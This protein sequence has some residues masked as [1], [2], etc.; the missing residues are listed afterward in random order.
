MCRSGILGPSARALLSLAPVC[1]RVPTYRFDKSGLSSAPPTASYW[2]EVT[3][4]S[5]SAQ[6]SDPAGPTPADQ[7]E[8]APIRSAVS[9]EQSYRRELRP[10]I[11]LAYAFSGSRSAA[12]DF[13]AG[14]APCCPQRLGPSL[15]VREVES[16]G[17]LGCG[18]RMDSNSS[19]GSPRP[20]LKPPRGAFTGS[21]RT[22]DPEETLEFTFRVRFRGVDSSHATIAPTRCDKT[23]PSAPPCQL[24]RVHAGTSRN[25]I[26]QYLWRPRKDSN[27]RHPV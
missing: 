22:T 4:I 20:M 16:L 14:G 27:L 11:G 7:T 13:F 9:F 6:R 18:H 3:A 21:R 2:I 17:P 24:W 15:A 8:P 1:S 5:R 25:P 23:L 26:P 19:I 10:V 12:E